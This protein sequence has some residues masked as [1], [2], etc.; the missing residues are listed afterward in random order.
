MFKSGD[1]FS[2]KD[3]EVLFKLDIECFVGDEDKELS[4]ADA[5]SGS[6]SA[7]SK[8][9]RYLDPILE[10]LSDDIEQCESD[11]KQCECVRGK[12][13]KRALVFFEM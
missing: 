3:P 12:R 9:S 5:P 7:E 6:F 13:E 4:L 8:P 2:F 11:V 10:V 1:L